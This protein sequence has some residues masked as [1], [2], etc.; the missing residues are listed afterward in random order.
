MKRR[1]FPRLTANEVLDSIEQLHSAAPNGAIEWA[2]AREVPTSTGG[3]RQRIDAIAFNCWRSKRYVVRAYEVKVSRA[4]FRK[5]LTQPGKS[6]DARRL[7][8]EFAFACPKGMVDRGEIPEWAG[9]VEVDH[10]GRAVTRIRPPRTDRDE[11]PATFLASVIRSCQR[12]AWVDKAA[13][14]EAA[15]RRVLVDVLEHHAARGNTPP[16]D[17]GPGEWRR[18]A[19]DLTGED[20]YA[21]WHAVDRLR[22]DQGGID[23]EPPPPRL[24]LW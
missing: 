7:C 5:E 18:W 20:T 3:H 21:L 13:A 10:R 6:A 11:W 17:A 9:L 19:E 2:F 14:Q 16:A 4:D 12:T 24:S 15:R 22:R 1:E 23:R 8:H